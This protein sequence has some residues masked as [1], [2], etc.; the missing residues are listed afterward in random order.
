MT[1]LHIDL[2]QTGRRIR[3]LREQEGM[4]V[5]ELQEVF[6]FTT[7]QAI[8]KWQYGECLPAVENLLVLSRL[9][10]TNVEGLLVVVEDEH[11]LR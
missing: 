8:Y 1:Y 3:A 10:H 7:P 9:F 11:L 6:G 4:S 2:E 5:R